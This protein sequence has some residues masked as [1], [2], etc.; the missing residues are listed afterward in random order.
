MAVVLLANESDF[1]KEVTD[2]QGTVLVDFFAP[3]CGHCSRL[4]PELDA[5]AQ[6]LADQVK[7]VK[8]NVDQNRSLAQKH[9]IMSLPTLLIFAKGSQVDKFSGFMP[10]GKLKTILQQYL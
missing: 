7:I 2:F 3:W 10:K 5:L 1:S 6:E 8:I 9:G 4:S